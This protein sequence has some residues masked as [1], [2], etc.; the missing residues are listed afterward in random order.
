MSAYMIVDSDGRVWFTETDEAGCEQTSYLGRFLGLDALA[1]LEAFCEAVG[2]E[3]NLTSEA[4][5]LGVA[6]VR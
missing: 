1:D 3:I 2:I 5:R 6:G 4:Q